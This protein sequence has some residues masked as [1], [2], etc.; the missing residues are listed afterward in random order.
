MPDARSGSERVYQLISA[1]SHVNEPPD[2]WTSRAPAALKDRVPRMER[3]EEGDAWIIEGIPTPMPFGLNAGA[4]LPRHKREAWLFWEEVR[5]GGYDP[6]ERIREMDEDL[7]DGEVLFPTPRL[8]SAVFATPDHELHLAMVRAYNDW[9]TEFAAHDP[10][11]L[12]ALP[13]VPNVGIDHALA[14]IERV[15]DRPGIGGVIIGQ[16]PHGG[17]MPTEEDDP[18]WHALV[19]RGLTANIH[20]ALSPAM[21]KASGTP[22]PLPGAGRHIPIGG[23]LLELIFSG[24]FDRIPDL[25]V[26]A[27]E[28]DCGWLPYF[29]EQC[30][31]N[32]R[33]FR[34]R[35]DLPHLPSEY[36]ERH[37]SFTFVTDAYGIRNRHLIGVERMMWSTDY[38]HPSASWPMSAA[39]ANAMMA[40]VPPVERQMML[41]DNARRVYR[42]D[43]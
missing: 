32:F 37:I 38:P 22:G 16:Y 30:D 3:F 11:R 1:D 39:V 9:L 28:V 34:H 15:G 41:A 12:K 26:V 27:A 40:G 21:P 33:R 35:F 42:F 24:T 13:V 4:G 17:V 5:A 10:S 25:H 31:D 20:V 23:Q 14:E 43:Q 36:F 7:V 2:L 29:K 19:E 8:F 6:A 18:V